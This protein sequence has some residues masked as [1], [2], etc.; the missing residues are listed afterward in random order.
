MSHLV[1][2]TNT[3]ETV[4]PVWDTIAGGNS[5]AATPGDFAG[6]YYYEEIPAYALDQ[7]IATHYTNFGYCDWSLL[8][9]ICGTNTGF[10]L[11]LGR[12]AA[13]FLAI[14]FV[15][16]S[17]IPVRDPITITVEGSNQTT[18]A[19]TLGSSWTLIYNGSSGLDIDPG[20]SK[21]GITKNI[22]N[23][24]IWYNS[25]R[26]LVTSIRG[27]GSSAWYSEVR[28]FGY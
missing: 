26:L 3:N 27:D 8:L 25:Y 11:T 20:R 2:L 7:N 21:N 17:D 9:P 24:I 23:N 14:Q 1:L 19:L 15:T 16:A 18:S 28:F 12:G 6:N 4:Y 5:K 10:Y 13:L 22:S